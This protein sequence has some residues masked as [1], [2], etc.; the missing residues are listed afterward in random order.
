MARPTIW[1]PD[2]RAEL[3]VDT[4][5]H[6]DWCSMDMR[7]IRRTITA[8]DQNGPEGHTSKRT[9]KE[10]R[11]ELAEDQGHESSDYPE[12][13]APRNAPRSRPRESWSRST[14]VAPSFLTPDEV[15][16]VLNGGKAMSVKV[17]PYRNGGWEVDIHYRLP[18]GRRDRER[19]R[20]PVSSKSA[21]LRWGQD[22]ERYLALHGTEPQEKRRCQR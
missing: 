11:C 5:L 17:R 18:N 7:N 19:S 3:P 6:E 1:M 15:S 12:V 2:R 8:Q 20:A 4:M 10:G 13:A 16:A 21:A 14:A 9:G 22:R